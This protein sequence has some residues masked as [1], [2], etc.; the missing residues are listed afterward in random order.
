[1]ERELPPVRYVVEGLIPEGVTLIGGK[2]KKGKTALLMHVGC[3]VAGGNVTLGSIS[4]EQ[5]EVLYMALED[6]ERRFQKRMRLMLEGRTPPVG[7]Y[8]VNEWPRLDQGGLDALKRYLD[9]RPATGLIIVDTL[10]HIRPARRSRDGV[11]ADDYGAIRGLQQLAGERRVAIVPLHHLR[12]ASAEDPFDEFN[13]SMGLMASVDNAVVLRSVN[14]VSDM[15]ELH[16]RGR[17]YEDDTPLAIKGD[18]ATLLWKLEGAALEAFRSAERQAIVNLLKNLPKGLT[19]KEIAQKLVKNENTTRRLLQNLLDEK[20]P[21]ITNNGGVY[22]TVHGV[23]DV[24]G[25]DEKQSP[26]MQRRD[27]FPFDCEQDE[28]HERKFAPPQPAVQPVSGRW[29]S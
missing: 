13:G 24:H 23:H 6:N 15:L 27:L 14:G 26:Q 19:P 5:V 2:A 12:K 8:F 29:A 1:M 28:H 17:D 20:T 25:V 11:Y 22:T 10:E 7:F 9:E 21:A 3:S 16:R 18:K 4:T